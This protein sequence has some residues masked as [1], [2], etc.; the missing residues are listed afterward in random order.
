MKATTVDGELYIE[1]EVLRLDEPTMNG[2]MYPRELF[3]RELVRYQKQ[4]EAKQAFVFSYEDGEFDT[5]LSRVTAIVEEIGIEDGAVRLR[6]RVLDT[7]PGQ[8]VKFHASMGS[9]LPLRMGPAGRGGVSADGVVSE[10]YRLE[11]IQ[12]AH[13][14]KDR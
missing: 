13:K 8:V 2:R 14:E 11:Y 6:A 7:R 3:E 4:V 5:H 9:E 10:D 12:V 1:G